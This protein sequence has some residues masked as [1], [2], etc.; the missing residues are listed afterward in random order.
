[1]ALIVALAGGAAAAMLAAMLY[2]VGDIFIPFIY[3]KFLLGIA[4][5][6]VLGA[7]PVRLLKW[8]KVRS[9]LLS[10]LTV[11]AVTVFGLYAVWVA[12]IWIEF[13][14][15]NLPLNFGWLFFHP[16]AIWRL[17]VAIDVDGTWGFENSANKVNGVFLW[18]IWAIEAAV[19]YYFA[20]S[21]SKKIMAAEPFCEDCG[22]WCGKP[23]RL[24]TTAMRDVNELRRQLESAEF[25]SVGP[26]SPTLPPARQ[27]L[28]YHHHACP[29]CG[30]LNTLSVHNVALVENRKSKKSRMVIKTV[31]DKLL[32]HPG[33]AE[34]LLPP[35][36][37]PAHT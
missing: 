26:L 8:G 13:E 17:A 3:I 16:K 14:R 10:T 29:K 27:W 1:V 34:L 2:A 7:V 21:T 37:P 36:T 9:N 22:I 12:W 33:E 20:R 11:E 32:L 28:S 25:S 4:L 23:R 18:I 15:S 35:P 31:I 24:G 19:I 30:Q 6:F 5:G